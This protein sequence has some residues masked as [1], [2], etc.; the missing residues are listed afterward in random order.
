MSENSIKS[1]SNLPKISSFPS[2]G[3]YLESR[4]GKELKEEAKKGN[5]AEISSSA[6]VE[7]FKSYEDMRSWEKLNP[8]VSSAMSQCIEDGDVYCVKPEVDLKD[9]P[10]VSDS[11]NKTL[12]RT[13]K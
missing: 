2:L 9:V 5:M 7:I 10:F 12:K 11:D 1:S 13:L 3:K 6:T 8:V 4:F